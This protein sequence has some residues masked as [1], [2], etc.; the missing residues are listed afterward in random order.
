MSPGREFVKQVAPREEDYFILKPMHSAFYQ[1]ALDVL[2]RYFEAS[3]LVLCG[4]ATNNCV[5]CTAHDAKMRDFQIIVG[6]DCCASATTAD[7]PAALKHLGI[8]TKAR[9][10][11]SPTIRLVR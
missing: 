9:I 2:L 10:L 6:A 5:V 8:V 7:H 4:I 1:T 11:Q 3:T